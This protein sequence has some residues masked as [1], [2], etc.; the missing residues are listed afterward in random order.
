MDATSPADALAFRVKQG[1][2]R[3]FQVSSLFAK[4]TVLENVFLAVSGKRRSQ[5]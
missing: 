2:V 3:T 4:L 5:P 1:L